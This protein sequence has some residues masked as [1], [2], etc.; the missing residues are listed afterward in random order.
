[1]KRWG[2]VIDLKRCIGCNS[3]TLAC[4]VENGT[5]PGIFYRRVLEK[6]TGKYPSVR[7]TYLPVQCMHCEDPPCVG[8]CPSGVFKKREDG[9]VLVDSSKCYGA[10]ACRIACPYNAIS[11]LEEI[12]TYYP[13]GITRTESMWYE[14]HMEGTAEKCNFCAERLDQGL[15]PA[16]VLACPAEVMKFGDLNDPRSDVSQLIKARD[17]F[18]LQPELGTNPSVYYVK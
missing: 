7:R 6:T 1:M 12:K 10:R 14:N 17:G 5:P 2:M 16:C 8:A 15:M 9:I 18:Q 13:D 4:K 3:C 11:F